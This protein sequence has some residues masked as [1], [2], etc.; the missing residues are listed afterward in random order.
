MKALFAT[1]FALSLATT[2]FA[3]DT[4]KQNQ[5]DSL[6]D[7]L[8]M[9]KQ[10]TLEDQKEL[11]ARETSF[12]RKRDEQ[13]R[14]LAEARAELKREE[15]RSIALEQ[16]F[17]QNKKTIREDQQVLSDK[18]GSLKELFGI[19]QQTA[20]DLQ[21]VFYNSAT[22]I[23]YPNRGDFLEAFAKKMSKASEI[24]T[25]EE[26]ERLWFELQREM[27]ETG[28]VIRFTAPVLGADGRE[29][30]RE[31]VRLGGFGLISND[32]N[33][34]YLAWRSEIQKL[35][36]LKRQPT[37]KALN[38][39]ESYSES[40]DSHAEL[41][42]DPTGGALLSRL[43]DSPTLSERIQQGGLVGYIILAVGAFA[44]LLAI[45]K[46]ITINLTAMKVAAQKR[47]V[48]N[49]QPNNPL[50]RVLQVYNAS[51]A[52]DIE[53]LEMRLA[54][55][56]LDEMPRINRFIVILKIISVVAPLMGL[57]GTVTGMINTFQAITLFGTGDP[58]TMAGGISQALVT[59]VLGLVVAIP[60]VVLHT[61]AA[62]RAKS[63]NHTLE[64]QAAGLIAEQMEAKKD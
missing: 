37:G 41:A 34:A 49:P 32:P 55:A 8:E 45:F 11:Q 42:V 48:A 53:T 62:S 61:I 5:A 56:I 26:V 1:L 20:G 6:D 54:E 7:L 2:A 22:S 3:E 29:T 39:V 64:H 4:P 57:L 25:I 16:Q 30:K 23:Q 17:D 46:L 36:E 50:G 18:L 63:I 43:V 60:T 27:T 35:A 24:S 10:G 9:V 51:K 44:M 40:T 52:L 12:K 14:L 28:K 13:A 31:V 19:F 59:T 47:N 38:Q 15:E 58:K 33:P 21:G